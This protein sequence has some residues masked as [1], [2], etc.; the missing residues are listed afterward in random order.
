[1][2]AKDDALVEVVELMRS[3]GLGIDEVAS[4]LAGE[5][6]FEASRSGSVLSRVFAYLGGILIFAGL[7]IYIGMKWDVVG[8]LGRVLMTL[9]PG[10]C[11]FVAA[12]VATTDARLEGAATPLFLV[13]ALL[14]PT[15]LVVILREFASGADPERG[16]LLINT[17]MTIQQGCTFLARRRT[18]LALTTAIFASGLFW[19]SLDL[20]DVSKDLIGT[21]LG[22]SLMCVAWSLDRSTHRAIAGLVYFFGSA[23]FLG[24]TWDWLNDTPLEP[25][26]IAISSGIVVLATMAHSR[27]LLVVGTI[28]LI[29]YLGDYIYENFANSVSAPLLLIAFGFVLIGLGAAAIRLNRKFIAPA[30][31]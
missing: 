20:L 13:A 14:E 24:A 17:V 30:A 16:M 23:T 4:A 28:A 27:S 9:G 10:A 25:L 7:A 29:G 1:M 12:L 18:V 3:H 5:R 15:G 31:T 22:I 11:L 2:G 8:P 19:N 26:F 21:A 6:E